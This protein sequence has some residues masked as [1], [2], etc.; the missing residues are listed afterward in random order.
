MR[1]AV[2]T[3]AATDPQPSD[4]FRGLYV[5][6]EA[7]LALANGSTSTASMSGSLRPRRC[8]ASNGLDL[9][10]LALCAAPELDPRFGRLLA[11]LHDD[12]TRRLA[13][14]RLAAR[15]LAD[16]P[17]ESDAVLARFAADAPLRRIGAVRLLD[18]EATTPVAERLVKVDDRLASHLLGVGA[19]RFASR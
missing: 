19:R 4:P 13:S 18:G 12:V 14:P 5:S 2:A 16:D 6:D 9:P 10:V 11:Y 15:L 17:V 8:S 7:A 3:V 1:R